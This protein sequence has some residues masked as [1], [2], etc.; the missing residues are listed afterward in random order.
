MGNTMRIAT[1]A[2]LCCVGTLVGCN[3]DAPQ[4]G[5]EK[6]PRVAENA[7]LTYHFKVDGPR[8]STNTLYY[9]V[10]KDVD[11]SHP[12]T[13]TIIDDF[14]VLLIEGRPG[15]AYHVQNEPSLTPAEKRMRWTV[16]A[17]GTLG[18]AESAESA[19]SGTIVVTAR[20]RIHVL[21]PGGKGGPDFVTFY[22]EKTNSS[23]CAV[24]DPAR[25]LI[26][27]AWNTQ[28]GNGNAFRETAPA[29][30]WTLEEFAPGPCIVAARTE[31]HQ[32]MAVRADIGPG[33][34]LDL[35]VGRQ[36]PGGATVICEDRGA[37]LLLAGEF[38]I[39]APRVTTELQY[40]SKWDGVPP[41]KHK[42]RY[43]DGRVVDVIAKDGETVRL[44]K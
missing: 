27:A 25:G 38:A 9:A 5:S 2:L 22:E 11:S 24:R 19:E 29:R 34:E 17:R 18:D 41:G 1:L 14:S 21:A 16:D 35:D 39:P 32:W 8:T 40:R 23:A 15:D 12:Y 36:P 30:P 37:L 33:T 4:D 6:P 31:G 10:G 13:G 43:P 28:S 44:D 42:M 3:G 7:G 26:T 20:A